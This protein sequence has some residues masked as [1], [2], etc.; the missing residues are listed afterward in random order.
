MTAPQAAIP[1]AMKALESVPPL[2]AI[3]KVFYPGFPDRTLARVGSPYPVVVDI[4][5]PLPQLY[6]IYIS[7]YNIVLAEV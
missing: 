3:A 7:I 2:L 4:V 1:P 6:F 5:R